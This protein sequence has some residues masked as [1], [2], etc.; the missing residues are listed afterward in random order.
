MKK[1][2]IV[3]VLIILSSNAFGQAL[4]EFKS[5]LENCWMN[6]TIPSGFVESKVISNKDMRYDYAVKYPDRDFELRYSISPIQTKKNR[7][8]TLTSENKE[9]IKF[10]NSNYSIILKAIILNITG[11]VQYKIQEFDNNAVKEEFNADW[12]AM[13]FVELNSAFGK[14]YKYCMIVA[15][16]KNDVAD[17]YYFYLSNTKDKFSENQ[18]PLFHTLKFD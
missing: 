2:N 6:V 7:N 5:T 15:I 12:G 10:R 16:H 9:Q 14:G 13:T 18:D 11:G 1:I 3:I 8:D 17:A 4:N